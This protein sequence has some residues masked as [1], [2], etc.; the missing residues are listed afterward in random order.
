M[1]KIKIRE[2]RK[3]TQRRTIS[4]KFYLLQE[5]QIIIVFVFSFVF[6]IDLNL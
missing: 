6:P 4:D 3:E 2:R 5:S 1:V